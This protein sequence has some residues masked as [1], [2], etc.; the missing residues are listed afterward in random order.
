LHR[1]AQ[2]GGL[3]VLTTPNGRWRGSAL[4]IS[5]EQPVEDWI[6][7]TELEMLAKEAGM[8]ILE[9]GTRGI[10]RYSSLDRY[11]LTYRLKT[12]LQHFRL[13]DRYQELLE[14]LGRGITLY[15]IL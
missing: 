12:I 2:P 1:I 4:P 14:S 8:K 9:I 7:Q 10:Y 15:A 3:I 13:W 11:I 5:A 6:L